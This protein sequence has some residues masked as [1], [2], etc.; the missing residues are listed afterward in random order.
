MFYLHRLLHHDRSVLFRHHTRQVSRLEDR[1]QGP[2][3]GRRHVATSGRRLLPVDIRLAVFCGGT[4]CGGG[5]VLRPVHGEPA[6]Q[7]LPPDRLLLDNVDRDMRSLHGHLSGRV[8]A[9]TEV[10]EKVQED[11]HSG[12]GR[13]THDDQDWNRD[14]AAEEPAAEAGLLSTRMLYRIQR[15]SS[16]RTNFRCPTCKKKEDRSSSIGFPSDSDP[17]ST[18]SGGSAPKQNGDTQMV[19]NYKAVE[20]QRSVSGDGEVAAK[21][22]DFVAPLQNKPHPV[23]VQVIESNG[24]MNAPKENCVDVVTSGMSN[25][26]ANCVALNTMTTSGQDGGLDAADVVKN[27]VQKPNTLQGLNSNN[28]DEFDNHD[29]VMSFPSPKSYRAAIGRDPSDEGKTKKEKTDLKFMKASEETD[30][31][32]PGKFMSF[33]NFRTA[34]RQ[35]SR[36]RG[37]HKSSSI[38]SSRGGSRNGQKGGSLARERNFLGSNPRHMLRQL[39]QLAARAR[40]VR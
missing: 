8:E 26:T 12:F 22:P 2:R 34:R 6:L 10:R 9:G 13:W 31:K 15:S 28:A 5:Q 37:R 21:P 23:D 30:V 27:Q 14:D 1:V 40:I 38:R 7:L 19:G 16:I 3:N 24:C 20:L 18:H 11:D 33:H 35:S 32:S 39:A 36:S 29:C 17:C 25:S 4:D